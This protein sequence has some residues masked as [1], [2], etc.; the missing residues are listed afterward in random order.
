[1]YQSIIFFIFIRFL[2]IACSLFGMMPF[3]MNQH[4]F[5]VDYTPRNNLSWN[6]VRSCWLPALVS[7]VQALISSANMLAQVCPRSVDLIS[8]RAKILWTRW[9]YHSDITRTAKMPAFWKFESSSIKNGLGNAKQVQIRD[10]VIMCI[11][12]EVRYVIS[13][14]AAT[15]RLF[16][17]Q[18]WNDC[19]QYCGTSR[20]DMNPSIDGQTDRWTDWWTVGWNQ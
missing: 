5:I 1:M 3:Y 13:N 16:P 15:S 12:N 20:A 18:I 2:A 8:S 9:A 19:S 6:C 10:Y 4:L 14:I 11:V 7:F 17:Y